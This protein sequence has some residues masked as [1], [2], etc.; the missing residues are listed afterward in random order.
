MNIKTIQ[1]ESLLKYKKEIN[2][3]EQKPKAKLSKTEKGLVLQV[4]II[5][6]SNIE[7]KVSENKSK[8]FDSRTF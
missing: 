1:Y 5:W 2:I 8:A 3:Q 6:K 4:L 7:S